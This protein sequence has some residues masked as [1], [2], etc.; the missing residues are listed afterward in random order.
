MLKGKQKKLD[1]NRDGKITAADFRL[2]RKA[3]KKRKT[4]TKTKTKKT[5]TKT[6][7][8]TKYKK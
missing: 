1:A 5:K 3:K 4:K 2:L 8:K 6:K 7:R